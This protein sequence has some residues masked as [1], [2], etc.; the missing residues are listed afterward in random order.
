M[1]DNFIS[2]LGVYMTGD[3]SR[4]GLMAIIIITTFIILRSGAKD[5]HKSNKGKK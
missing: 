3:M 4:I 5:K 2:I 1:S